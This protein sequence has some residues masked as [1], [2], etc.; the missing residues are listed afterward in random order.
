MVRPQLQQDVG[1]VL[2]FDK[3][4]A[5]LSEDQKQTLDKA[6]EREFG[7]LLASEFGGSRARCEADLAARGLTT[8]QF[9]T[10]LK[11]QLVARQFAREELLPRVRIARAELREEFDRNAAAYSSPGT[12][13]LW[14]I[15]APFAAFLDDGQSWDTARESQQAQARLRAVRHIRAAHAA[16]GTRPFEE[17]AREFSR[18]INAASGGDWGPIGEPLQLPLEAA[19]R[20]IFD[21]QTGQYSA[22]IETPTGWVIV[23]CG[24]ITPAVTASF[25]DTQ[26]RVRNELTERRFNALL[27]E[28]ITDLSN[29][30]TVSSFDSFVAATVQKA[31]R[32]GGRPTLQ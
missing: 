6:V 21:Y 24:K 14:M 32:G 27:L 11:R 1:I 30:A 2:L 4:V 29:R 3:A 10:R 12:R 9:K 7:D 18:G 23:R 16:L 15:E 17:V 28:Y 8:E 19:T 25:A 22:P 31:L 13:E 26:E 20:L 5:R